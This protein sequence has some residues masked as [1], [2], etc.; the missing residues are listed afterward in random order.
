M[1]IMPEYHFHLPLADEEALRLFLYHGFGFTLPDVQVCEDHC[2]P[3]RAFA[4]AFFGKHRV[5]VWH[6]SRGFGGKSLACAMLGLTQ[7]LTL[8]CDVTILG[9]SGQQSANVHRYMTKAWDYPQAPRDLLAGDPYKM[10]TR[11]SWGNSIKALLASQ[12]SVRGPHPVKLICDEVDEM[13]PN[14]WHASLGQPMSK[15]GV[16]ASIVLSSTLQY[17]DGTMAEVLKMAAER[18][19]GIYRWC[20]QESMAGWLAEA[21]VEAKRNEI[22]AVM[23]RTEYE[24]QEPS[25]EGRAI[26]PQCVAAMFEA[27]LGVYEGRN[28][29]YIEAEPPQPGASYR[30]GADWAKTQNFT[31]IVTIRDD[32]IPWRVVAFERLNRRPWPEMVARLDARLRRYPGGARHDSTG[33]GNVVADLLTCEAE[34][35]QLIGRARSDL[36]SNYISHIEQGRIV[37]PLIQFM[38]A[39]HQYCDVSDL[40]GSGHPPDSFVA[41]ALAV[42]AEPP[43]AAQDVSPSDME[44]IWA[45]AGIDH[46]SPPDQPMEHHRWHRRGRYW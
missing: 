8:K 34:G 43:M 32:V 22:P 26:L 3:W 28:G 2:S 25:S 12:A 20:Y 21:E 17:A 7:A 40:Y 36:F 15:A 9:G 31:C 19:W 42:G 38:Q 24:L 44:K 11:L 1:G 41:G 37:A 46:R 45:E 39:E 16:D 27:T 10:E 35:V 14:I 30:T 6:S 23:W 18:Q 5:S 4:D 29:E 13:D 33:L